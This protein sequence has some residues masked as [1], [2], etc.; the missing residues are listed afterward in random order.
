[1]LLHLWS[2]RSMFHALPGNGVV[3]TSSIPSSQPPHSRPTPL[4]VAPEQLAPILRAYENNAC[5]DAYAMAQEIGPL[6]AWRGTEARLLAG[7]LA[8]NLG[9]LRLAHVLHRLA[10]REAPDDPVV[11]SY[12]LRLVLERFGPL[13]A[14]R[15]AW[16][17]GELPA[18]PAVARADW[19]AAWA[20][21]AAMLRDFD[22]ADR[23]I[24]QA[25]ELAPRRAW[26]RIEQAHILEL[27]D[28]YSE[29]LTAARCSLELH[30]DYRPGLQ[31]TAHLLC[32][33]QRDQ[34]ALELLR[35][36]AARSQSGPLM[37]QLAALQIELGLYADARASYERIVELMPL[38]DKETR[39]WL[40]ARRSDAAY[41]C[42]DF[43]AARRLAEEAGGDFH[44]AVAAALSAPPDGSRRILL[45]VGFVRQH[46]ATCAPATL[47]AISGFWSV[48]AEHL[49][50]VEEIC[51]DGTPAHSERA[52]AESNGFVVREF[53]VT[54][55]S[56]VALIDRGVPFTLT[57]V[58]PTNAHLQAVVGY[59][60]RRRTL[61]I[62]DP[63]QRHC[64]EFIADSLFE[65]HRSTGPRGMLL[66]PRDRADLLEGIELPD[67][68]LYD[69][70]HG[71]NTALVA[72]QRERA[73]AMIEQMSQLAPA[74][75]LT[76]WARR[77]LAGY[78][79]DMVAQLASV[80][81]LLA[82]FPDDQMLLYHKAACLGRLGR[83]DELI[84][85]LEE[86]RSRPGTDPVF[87]QQ[88]AQELIADVRRHVEAERLLRRCIRLR[89][90]DA[91]ACFI[92]GNL[93]WGQRRFEEALELY[94]LAA[95]LNDKDEQLVMSYFHASRH[96]RK[97]Q[98]A[99]AMLQR[100]ARRFGNRS[101]RP[102]QSFFQA[103]A[104]MERTADGFAM[105]EE[106]MSRRP[107]DDELLLFAAD[108]Y[109]RY[110]RFQKA[111]ELLT[112]AKDRSH[113][114]AWLRVAAELA[115]YRGE[116]HQSLELWTAVL[117]MEPLAPD[118]LAA[119]ARL[120]AATAGP[121]AAV[122]HLGRLCQQFPH[123]VPLRHLLIEWLREEQPHEAEKLVAHL[124][125]VDPLDPTLHADLAMLQAAQARYADALASA[126]EAL[127]LAPS[128][129][130]IHHIGGQV[131]LAAGRIEQARSHWRQAIH[132]SVDESEAIAALLGSCDNTAQ[133]REALAF[134]KGQLQRQVI[135][136]DG[137]LAYQEQASQ[138][139]DGQE[140]TADLREAL[141]QRPDLWHAW[142]ALVRQL[143]DCNQLE[144]ARRLAQEA[145]ERFGLLPR[146]WLDLALVCQLTGEEA[147]EQA[148][149]SEALK[150]SPT[151]VP[152]VRRLSF[153]H[154]RR[155]EFDQARAV[156]EKAVA[157]EP[158]DA[159]LQAL[160]AE[161]LWKRHERE[162][163]MSR[164][165]QAVRLDVQLE[166]GWRA[167]EEW[168]AA[169]G[170]PNAAADLARELT[171][172]RPRDARC[173]IN[174]A[175][176][177]KGNDAAAEQLEAL[178]RAEE[179]VPREIEVHDL[180]A[181]VLASLGRF[182][183]AQ[184]ACSPP[185]WNGHPPIP[186]RGRAAWLLAVQGD[187]DAAVQRMQQ[188]VAE[189]PQF[190]W[191]WFRLA[192][193]HREAGRNAENL[194]VVQ[195]IIRLLPHD[196]VA[197]VHL[198]DAYERLKDPAAARQAYRRAVQLQPDHEYAALSLF[199][200]ALA[201]GDMEEATETL[202]HLR[203]HIGGDQ[204]LA[205]EVRLLA[206]NQQW[207]QAVEVFRTLCRS[208]QA[209]I[210]AVVGA[211][212]GLGQVHRQRSLGLLLEL[213]CE[214]PVTPHTG[215]LWAHQ[216]AEAGE[217]A[218]LEDGLRRLRYHPLSPP[219]LWRRLLGRDEPAPGDARASLHAAACACMEQL[220]ESG[221]TGEL[222]RFI[223]RHR[224]W[225]ALS[226][227]SWGTV[228]RA[229]VALGK[230]GRAARWMV[231]WKQRTDAEAWMLGNLAVA[232]RQM[233]QDQEAA[234]VSRHA[235][236]LADPE[237]AYIHRAW[238]ALDEAL[239][240]NLNEAA[241]LA[242]RAM[243][244]ED[245]RLHAMVK[246]LALAMVAFGRQAGGDKLEA[247]GMARAAVSRA[248]QLCPDHGRSPALRLAIRR[249]ARKVWQ[250][251]R[252]LRA[253]LWYW[254]TGATTPI[255][256]TSRA[257]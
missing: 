95:C 111:G 21:T 104:V 12:Y 189:D 170:R 29:A 14:W 255:G 207:P 192:D 71:V 114:G 69:L 167:L 223:A 55:E 110:G 100:R 140:L 105:L 5:L 9:S 101:S 52:W 243:P 252:L 241:E 137:L 129:S 153:L 40:A 201:D 168:G 112:A 253:R 184:A 198:A 152:A 143:V 87:W 237:P 181:Q 119:T 166:W 160:L 134:V 115:A 244:P 66:V 120:T 149:L 67:A 25:M 197:H 39:R 27:E 196:A 250:T 81:S 165:E 108:A 121:A 91:P 193:W 51:F 156:L 222:Q 246:A 89:P 85:L 202:E 44:K 161:M 219:P 144:E 125:K 92:L 190:V 200:L 36:A 209:Q 151:W 17:R 30:P 77:A 82:L 90:A 31:A 127:R 35:N 135:L 238:L 58:E 146:A 15:F 60:S 6:A 155:G 154:E 53:T 239:A 224:R 139:L 242:A 142:A 70:L 187:V 240:G 176:L 124:L 177:A 220:L 231:D 49:A 186:L 247:Y 56:A 10:W 212:D 72:H 221:R 59:D 183:E 227:E 182:E 4:V 13:A 204:T 84:R 102:A 38:A 180:R 106:A 88:Y 99:L 205:R 16:R 118:A 50:I 203:R 28:R 229:W 33:M 47:A 150:I 63:Y 74:H 235:L 211:F 251:T 43:D 232:L 179:L 185:L 173:W 116:L 34:E 42:G 109:G 20:T 217:L 113:R 194:E 228:G 175:R 141:A 133:R 136:G 24:A 75:R 130:H 76:A 163:A 132:L 215:G 64:G 169:M 45:P 208:P 157:A 164:M 145:T 48:P 94:R 61:L 8:A 249:C 68:A 178:R 218:L 19:L 80:E 37:T 32:L 18:A 54:W 128:N 2:G 174:L 117:A 65:S 73:V 254:G 107:E 216:L 62:R 245:D 148:A 7:R 96:F 22:R 257:F 213:A 195:T 248:Q 172:R 230:W 78:D 234:A 79:G 57:T 171:G 158:L 225:L 188:I 162:A 233:G 191:G 123:S 256:R 236:G 83:R 23:L 226:T 103:C 126:A 1:M 159:S 86:L 26:L 131:D 93:L 199:D 206:R 122:E 41:F 98:E 11:L 46:H 3:A 210:N 138:T 214:E 97:D 147:M